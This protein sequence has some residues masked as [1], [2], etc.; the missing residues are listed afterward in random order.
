MHSNF[1]HDSDYTQEQ[2]VLGAIEKGM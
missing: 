2:M 1:S